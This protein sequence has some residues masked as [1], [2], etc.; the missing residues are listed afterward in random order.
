MGLLVC[1][2]VLK[3]RT[4]KPRMGG[5]EGKQPLIRLLSSTDCLILLQR[6]ISAVTEYSLKN[7]HLELKLKLE[8]I[9]CTEK[10]TAVSTSPTTRMETAT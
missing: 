9:A 10:S 8:R 5:S 7:C 4:M 3:E 1:C 6:G 2:E